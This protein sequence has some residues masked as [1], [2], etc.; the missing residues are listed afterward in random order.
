MEITDAVIVKDKN[1][2]HPCGFGFIIFVDPT[3]CNRV[4]EDKHV[5]DGR[6]VRVSALEAGSTLFFSSLGH[7][8]CLF[9]VLVEVV[10]KILVSTRETGGTTQCKLGRFLC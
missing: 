1:M 9:L 5:I 8:A 7:T 4:V 3:V 10:Y 2:G 6:T